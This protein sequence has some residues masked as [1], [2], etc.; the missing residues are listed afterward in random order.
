MTFRIMKI[1][2]HY[3]INITFFF[4]YDFISTEKKKKKKKKKR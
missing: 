3:F 2:E 1:I 4:L